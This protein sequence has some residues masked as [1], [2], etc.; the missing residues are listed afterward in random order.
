MSLFASLFQRKR[1]SVLFRLIEAQLV[2]NV[3]EGEIVILTYT[4][5]ANT[6]KMKVFSTFIRDGIENGDR[7]FY[8]Y[9]DGEHEI[10]RNAL[11]ESGIDVDR[12]IRDGTLFMRSLTEFFMSNGEFGKEKAVQS[13]LY[14]WNEAKMKGYKHV[15]HIED[16]GNFSFLK[17]RWQQYIK[18]YWY[19]PRW[20][21]PAQY[22]E[23]VKTR[24]PIGVVYTSFLME[25]TALNV[26]GMEEEEI[27]ELFKTFGKGTT[28]TPIRFIDFLKHVDVFSRL[29]GL[30]HQRLLNRKILLEFDPASDYET[31]VESFVKEALANM[32]QVFIFTHCK[33]ILHESLSKHPGVKFLLT[34]SSAS[35][36]RSASKNEVLLPLNN[37]ALALDHLNQI[38]EKHV[39]IPICLVFD[40]FSELLQSR[41]LDK[42]R[43]F[44]CQI[45]DMLFARKTIAMFLLNSG[46]HEFRVLSNL[47]GLFTNQL[48]FGKDGLKIIK[49]SQ[50]SP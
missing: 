48:T 43:I 11:I 3:R 38:L 37:F 20:S 6:N 15:R 23:W 35:T 12:Y 19:D 22:P 26:G 40:G 42:T 24:D 29:I 1:K 4:P 14:F 9:P 28:P 33:S 41:G 27:A 10:V 8:L 39:G 2:L 5:D 34:S 21:D 45:L 31:I 44:I 7:I 49:I 17:G 18:D 47:K 13:V 32:E 50:K 36:S 30:D 46:A 16:V 25:I